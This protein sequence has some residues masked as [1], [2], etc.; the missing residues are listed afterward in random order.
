MGD[1]TI[2]VQCL[3]KQRFENREE[4]KLAAEY[5]SKQRRIKLRQYHCPA[6][7]GYHLSSR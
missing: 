7:G 3:G 1:H 5:Q 2:V 4:A 6:C